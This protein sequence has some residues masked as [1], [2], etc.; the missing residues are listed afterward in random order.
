MAEPT[1]RP[2]FEVGKNYDVSDFREAG[3]FAF[4][5]IRLNP[6]LS[7]KYKRDRMIRWK[8]G[9]DNYLVVREPNLV[10]VIHHYMSEPGGRIK[11]LKRRPNRN[12]ERTKT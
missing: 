8:R 6:S 12:G 4:K 9:N 11:N 1:T 2:R 7:E 10:R 3:Y 5:T